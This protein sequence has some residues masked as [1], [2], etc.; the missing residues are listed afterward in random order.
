[1]NKLKINLH[2]K[3]YLPH[4]SISSIIKVDSNYNHCIIII[5]IDFPLNLGLI[6][7]P[8]I[9]L[10]IILYFKDKDNLIGLHNFHVILTS[11]IHI[12]FI[13]L[14]QIFMNFVLVL[15]LFTNVILSE[16]LFFFM[17]D[18]MLHI[19]YFCYFQFMSCNYLYRKVDFFIYLGFFF[20]IIIFKY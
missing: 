10:F 16:K 7:F 20:F 4:V 11:L 6:Y 17:F 14:P 13:Y 3:I 15:Q 1:M 18:R 5:K 2:C 8:L 9:I 12:L 19:S